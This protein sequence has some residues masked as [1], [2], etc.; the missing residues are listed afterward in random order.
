MIAAET[1]SLAVVLP[2]FHR[3]NRL[4]ALVDSYLEQ[5][6][7]EVIV[8]LDG[9]HQ[10]WQSA[11]PDRP[12][13]HVIELP[14][15]RGLALARIAGLEAVAS[16]VVLAVD[17][18]VDP[19]HDLV[20]RHR[21]FH[22]SHGADAV[23]Q[24]YMPIERTRHISADQAPTRLYA[25]DYEVQVGVWRRGDSSTIL[26]SLWGGNVSL[27]REL[28]ERAE[29]L[30]PSQRLE[31]NEDLDLGLRL[32][33]LGAHATFDESA[34]GI[35]RHSRGLSAYL[36]E[37]LARGG[38]VADLEERWGERPDQ[39]N[40]TVT[41]PPGYNKALAFVQRGIAKR[42]RSGVLQSGVIVIY[43]A[44]GAARA[45]KLQDAV[46][47]LLRRAIIM[48]GYRLARMA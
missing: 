18:D 1:P 29:R 41:I 46:T 21:R 45:W 15:N 42:D 35:H 39:L 5:G 9:P 40:P 12:R 6:S 27:R 26:R 23:L 11:L 32:L 48:R 24:G 28:Y 36:R 20:E 13:L 37:C 38:A 4:P 25:R 2:S 17:D 30:K 16:D 47:R 7:D 10:G 14:E 31:Y 3:L 43:R 44:A 33:E 34:R 22:A 19:D 8:V